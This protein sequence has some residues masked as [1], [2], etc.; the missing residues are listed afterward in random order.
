MAPLYH[1]IINDV[2]AP[3]QKDM[4]PQTMAKF[5]AKANRPAARAAWPEL[6]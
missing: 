4:S 5:K 6:G 2:E 1:A 3:L